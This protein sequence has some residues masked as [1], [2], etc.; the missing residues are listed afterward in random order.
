[1][2]WIGMFTHCYAR[3]PTL[4][5]P[6]LSVGGRRGGGGLLHV[7][8][9][10]VYIVSPSQPPPPS[11]NFLAFDMLILFTAASPLDTGGVGGGGGGAGQFRFKQLRSFFPEEKCAKIFL[12]F[13]FFRNFVS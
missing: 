5:P 3:P 6:C 11:D 1:M 4:H 10:I 2:Q 9:Y 8:K 13:H 7:N 12:L